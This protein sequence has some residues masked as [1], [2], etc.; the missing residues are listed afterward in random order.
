MQIL[1]AAPFFPQPSRVHGVFFNEE[2]RASH[3]SATKRKA[4]SKEGESHACLHPAATPFPPFE[5]PLGVRRR[6]N[7]HGP[8]LLLLLRSLVIGR[9]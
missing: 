5:P 1:R 4:T 9:E 8:R 6:L 3:L 2:T 7:L